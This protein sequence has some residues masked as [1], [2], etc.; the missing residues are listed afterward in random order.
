[1]RQ[2]K[3]L[4]AE[5]DAAMRAMLAEELGRRG[6]EVRAF[7]R[8][9]EAFRAFPEEAFDVVLTDLRMPGMS[10]IALCERIAAN[11][12][13][14]PVIVLTAFGSL[15]SAVA[16][17]RAGAFDFVSKPVEMEV[18]AIA[19]ARALEHRAL[20]REVRVLHEAVQRAGRFEDLLGKSPP[21]LDLFSVLERA[22]DSEASLLLVG[23]SG[24]GKE[25]VARAVHARSRRS[26]GPF[27]AVNC[28][29]LPDP[30][31]ES[32]LFGHA[33]G[34]FTDA[35]RDRK[36]IFFQADGGTLFLDEIGDGSPS[37]QAKVLRALEERRA[38]PLGSDREIPFDVRLVSA[39][40]RELEAPVEEGRFREDL[41]F[42]INVVRVRIPPLR[43][44]GSD[45]LLLAQH[46]VEGLAARSERPPPRLSD[47]AARM[48]LDY[49][50][51]GN[52]R[53]LRNA[54]ERAVTLARGDLLTAED[55][56][57]KIRSYRPE[58]VLVGSEDPTELVPME[59]LERRY[60][61]NV[62]RA[63]R[64]N[65]TTAARVLGFDRKTLYRKIAR[66]GIEAPA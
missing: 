49:A 45:V 62:L 3:V 59:E 21:M 64:G 41:Y 25:V 23:E 24:T 28:G 53:E 66:Y 54:M 1:M 7:A 19:I 33:R 56:P 46:F 20:R 29:A 6:L 17:I 39:T 40:H 31:V 44:R 38:R 5:D 60:I 11:D 15:E 13:D 48:L 10:G 9:E 55:L 22:A 14:V 34:A 12:P 30:L 37:F 61:G 57:E 47:A 51:P 50:W 58:R 63:V 8:S 2:G 65:K 32:E 4:L 52:V 16:A 18:L 27:A 26:R 36:G 35:R 42:R 43:E